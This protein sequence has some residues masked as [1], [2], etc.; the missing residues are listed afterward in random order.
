MREE[1][2]VVAHSS[3]R[4][5]GEQTIYFDPFQVN[6]EFHDADI[7]LVTHEHHD[8]YSP[9]DIAKVKNSSSILVCP[10]SMK[11]VLGDSGMEEDFIEFVEPGDELEI[12]NVKIEAVRSYNIGKPFHPKEKDWVGYVVTMN[13]TRYFVAGDTDRNEDN[14]KV[15]CD[16]ALLPVGGKYTMTAEEAAGL[17]KVIRP[18]VAIPTHYG[19][20]AGSDDDGNRFVKLLEGKVEAYIS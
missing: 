13:Q 11:A 17:A 1:I 3:I 18:K 4:I 20:V 14:E 7:I 5:T 9:E 16:V 15:E 10:K 2:K 19:S 6:Q 12:N 8:H